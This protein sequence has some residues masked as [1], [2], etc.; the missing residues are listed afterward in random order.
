ME[1]SNVASTK[2][3]RPVQV[4]MKDLK[5]V[6]AGKR[7][8]EYN[9]RKKEELAQAAKDQESEPKLTSSQA[10]GLS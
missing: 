1:N 4:T 8:A 9:H 10:L 2:V 5:K 3:E 6:A 7:I